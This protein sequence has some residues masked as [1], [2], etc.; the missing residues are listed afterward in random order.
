MVGGAVF[1]G[2][3]PAA[4]PT[5]VITPRPTMTMAATSA[6]RPAPHQAPRLDAFLN[7]DISDSLRNKKPAARPI[8]PPQPEAHKKPPGFTG[9]SLRLHQSQTAIPRLRDAG[10]GL[11]NVV[12]LRLWRDA[13]PPPH[14]HGQY[15]DTT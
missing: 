14:E 13:H 5:P 2:G 9:I 3:E 7:C 10:G 4:A 6:P 11:G 8:G 15:S 12:S 1:D